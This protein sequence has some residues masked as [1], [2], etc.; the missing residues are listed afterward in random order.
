MPS[1]LSNVVNDVLSKEISITDSVFILPS[2]RA[3]TFL[4]QEIK[5]RIDKP[6]LFPKII[7]IEDFIFELSSISLLDQTALLFE[8]YAV[9][10]E[11]TPKKSIE[12]FDSF[13]K[14]AP[15]VL[16]DFNEIDRHKIDPN[17]IFDYLKSIDR[18]EKWNIEK[19]AETKLINNYLVFFDNLEVYYNKLYKQL[20]TKKQGYQGIQYREAAENIHSYIEN[21]SNKKLVFTG[22]NALNKAEEIIIQELLE[23]DLATIYWDVDSYYF[24]EHPAS[25][26]LRK[27]KNNWNYFKDTHFNWIKNDFNS[28]KIIKVIGTPKNNTQVKYVSEILAKINSKESNYLNTALVL[29]DE[30]LLPIVLSSLPQSVKEIN[31]TMGYDLYNMPIISLIESFFKLH[32]D[33]KNSN[34]S[35]YYKH[36]LSILNHSLI[37]GILETD[38]LVNQI[39]KN[40]FV[41]LKKMSI[42]KLMHYTSINLNSILFLFDDMQDDPN[43]AL[44]SCIELIE[45]LKEQIDNKLELEFLFKTLNVLNQINQLNSKTGY[46]LNIKALYRLYKNIIKLEKLSFQG[47]PLSGLQLMGMLETRVLD[48][49]NVILT[50]VNE[51]MLPAGKSDNSFIPFDVKKEVGLPTYQERDAIF[52]YHF[53]RLIQRAKNVYLLYNTENDQYGSG[54][55]SRFITELEINK[56]EAI[57]KLIISPKVTSQ[58]NKKLKV[59]KTLSITNQLK[60]LAQ[61]GF[62]PTSLTNYINNPIGFYEQT[63]LGIKK[64]EETEETIAANTL[65]TIIHKTLEAFYIPYK[66][67]VLKKEAILLMKKETQFEVEKWFK[68]EYKNGDI[69]SGKNLLIYNVAKQFIF[70]FLNQELKLLNDGK[71]LKIL[72]LEYN[73]EA[74]IRINGIDFPIKLKGQ[75]DRIDELDGVLRI[76][77]YKT[78]KVTQNDLKISDWS[79][80]TSDYKYSK[81]FQVL[82][83]AFMYTKM[84]RLKLESLLME[85]GI[86]SFKNL[87]SGFLKVNR[88]NI[89]QEDI[90]NF[91][92]QLERLILEIFNH[93]IPFVENE[94]TYF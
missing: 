44:K 26:F 75:A 1:F 22:F 28:N 57:Q 45:L 6:L 19:G 33:L 7:S 47:E 91:T 21:N 25:I 94:N 71:E 73:L 8:F 29:A 76:I 89:D 68:K 93:N 59:A 52:S 36:V 14:W 9:Y 81:S 82:M 90:E 10:L 53:Y 34:G 65:G 63:I 17:Y 20:T 66:G 46:L 5:N 67:K 39:L 78:G 84:N 12:T 86:I 11:N 83:Y 51:G 4:K 38:E 30:S 15:T 40:N 80:I 85:S 27:Y 50:S 62:S 74:E 88:K 60:K 92:S 54:E 49:E 87:N 58:N 18:L 55:Q 56:P 31:I 23:N 41:Y 32:N 79:L 3:G 72:K 16:Q 64:N 13:S 42:Q 48:F 43:L 37:K 69:T 61:K 35:F 77:D 70:N 2:K 24:K